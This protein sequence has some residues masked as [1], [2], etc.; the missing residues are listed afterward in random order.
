MRTLCT[1]RP[2][3]DPEGVGTDEGR[4]VGGPVQAVQRKVLAA[5]E[6]VAG[7]VACIV[8]FV[9]KG[10]GEAE[11]VEAQSGGT[12]IDQDEHRDMAGETG[13]NAPDGNLHATSLVH[14]SHCS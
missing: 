14:V 7:H 6:G 13:A 2:L 9:A 10:E 8:G 12:R 1:Y 3:E 4:K 5:N 11:Q